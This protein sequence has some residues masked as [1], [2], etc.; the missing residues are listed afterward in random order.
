MNLPP[1]NKNNQESAFKGICAHYLK[2]LEKDGEK[3]YCSKEIKDLKVKEKIDNLISILEK[4]D[5]KEFE[6]F[7]DRDFENDIWYLL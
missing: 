1:I 4:L 2:Y 6:E 7:L 5:E 3:I